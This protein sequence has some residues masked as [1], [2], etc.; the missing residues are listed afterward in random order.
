MPPKMRMLPRSRLITL[1]FIL[2]M[3]VQLGYY[4]DFIEFQEPDEPPVHDFR[5]YSHVDP[6]PSIQVPLHSLCSKTKWRKHVYINCTDIF[7]DAFSAINQLQVCVR[8]AIDAG[9]GLVRPK[10]NTLSITNKSV[11]EDISY[12]LDDQFLWQSLAL[13]CPSLQIVDSNELQGAEIIEGNQFFFGKKFRGKGS[14]GK[15]VQ[16]RV[17]HL[18]LSAEKPVVIQE[19]G[20]LGGWERKRDP[21]PLQIAFHKLFLFSPALLTISTRILSHLPQSFYSVHLRAH[22]FILLQK[23]PH[24]KDAKGTM[25]EYTY[26]GDY[27]S[28]EV[29]NMLK[30]VLLINTTSYPLVYVSCEDGQRLNAFTKRA[31]ELSIRVTHKFL[32]PLTV[33]AEF[34]AMKMN[35]DQ[36]RIVDHLVMM[37]SEYFL[38]TSGSVDSFMLGQR[39][40]YE[41]F[42]KL[43]YHGLD[44]QQYLL[45][46]GVQWW[47]GNT[48]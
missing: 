22:D 18:D 8:W 13:N 40:H 43:D 39:R 34:M 20:S 7:M 42:G 47:T 16:R 10:L 30:E 23:S 35:S 41:Q 44:N 45:G 15:S 9:A 12:L 28:D 21:T 1:F 38:G 6:T 5:Q 14:Y 48:W 46:P 2:A 36:L 19:R 24:N 3:F 4:F 25:H 27:E 17:Y 33:D 32:A 29:E 11:R 26:D 37:R 31:S